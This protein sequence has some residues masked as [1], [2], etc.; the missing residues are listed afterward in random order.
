M[1]SIIQHLEHINILYSKQHGF[2][3]NHPCETQLLLSTEDLAKNLDERSETDLQ[4]CDFSK[5]FDKV[6]HQRLISKLNYYGI[7]GKTLAWINSWLTERFQGVVMG[8]EAST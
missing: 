5:A 8:G 2:R 1:C 7:Q 4:T 6:P 3:K